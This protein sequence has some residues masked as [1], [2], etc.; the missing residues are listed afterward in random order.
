MRGLAGGQP[1]PHIAFGASTEEEAEAEHKTG[2]RDQPW[3]TP[4]AR[5]C[6]ALPLTRRHCGFLTGVP[7]RAA[8]I[9]AR[10]AMSGYRGAGD[11]RQSILAKFPLS[12]RLS[13]GRLS[14]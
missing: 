5:F 9:L 1:L 2:R 3:Q 11:F 13:T 6:A 8:H 4:A 14:A 10:R 12:Y 7:R